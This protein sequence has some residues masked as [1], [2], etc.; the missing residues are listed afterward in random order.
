MRAWGGRDGGTEDG[1]GDGWPGSR[2]RARRQRRGGGS[3]SQAQ[4]V[5]FDGH[6]TT[7]AEEGA[8]ST[9]V[10]PEHERIDVVFGV[11]PGGVVPREP[12]LRRAAAEGLE[13]RRVD[14]ARWRGTQGRSGPVSCRD[15]ATTRETGWL[16]RRLTEE[17]KRASVGLTW[18]ASRR[19]PASAC[20]GRIQRVG[21][22]P[23]LRGARHK[24]MLRQLRGD[25]RR[26]LKVRVGM[27]F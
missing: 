14:A 15:S 2:S 12:T 19:Q 8:P 20:P 17:T 26:R 24:P 22:A 5:G 1:S 11:S 4:R 23:S 7:V 6:G 10:V 27:V 16:A 18:R 13:D 9:D 25:R 3:R 21:P